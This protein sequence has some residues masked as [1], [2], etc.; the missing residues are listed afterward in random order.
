MVEGDKNATMLE[1]KF[2]HDPSTLY[3]KLCSHLWGS[4]LSSF[5]PVL[6]TMSVERK[7]NNST[8]AATDQCH[9]LRGC[10]DATYL[11]IHLTLQ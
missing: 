7:K 8:R 9:N 10:Q 1:R 5:V 6:M 2:I 3:E 11:H 4:K